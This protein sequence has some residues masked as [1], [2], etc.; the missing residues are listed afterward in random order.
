MAD[1]KFKTALREVVSREF[2]DIP[3]HESEINYEFSTSFSRKMTKLTKA[4]QSRFWR[5]TNTAPKR[6]AVIVI[7]FMLIA[8]T[9]C[10]IP[11]VRAAIVNFIKET[12]DTFIRFFT[13]D[14]GTKK[15]T[16]RYRLAEI[17]DGYVETTTLENDTSCITVYQNEAGEQIILSQSIT[18]N[19][20]IDV[21]N[22]NGT[23]SEIVV[24]GMEVIIYEADVCTVAI[25]MNDQY[26]FDLTFYGE[27]DLELITELIKS[28]QT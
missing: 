12:H 4:E 5:M 13:D 19:Y 11:P 18:D 6:A 16:E 17:P 22:E 14:S 21:D 9:A 1:N 26:A 27:C 20:A 7:V 24:A 15:I 23:L 3:M 28:L 8:L 2:S 25:W 10:S